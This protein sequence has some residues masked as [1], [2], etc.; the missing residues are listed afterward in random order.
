[1][2]NILIV[3]VLLCDIVRVT[4]CLFLHTHVSQEFER[5]VLNRDFASDP[6]L[7]LINLAACS[8]ITNRVHY[9]TKQAYTH[10]V[11]LIAT[12]PFHL[13]ALIFC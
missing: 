9:Q 11:V 3:L 1:M 7:T 12:T 8:I 6:P 4:Q 2:C 13:R 10:N 5:C